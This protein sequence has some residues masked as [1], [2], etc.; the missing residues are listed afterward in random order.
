LPQKQLFKARE[1]AAKLYLD[2]KLND[3]IVDLVQASRSPEDYDSDLQRW[4]R[5][6]ASPRA[7][8]ALARCARARAWLDGDDFVAP[9]HIQSVAPDVLRHR[10]LL[11][12]EG[13]AEGV[14]TDAYIRRLLEV[15]A[16]P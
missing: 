16:I 12:F 2:A 1:D 8:I 14:T 15:A 11:T 3:Y 7:T 6:G 5:F 10:I 9:H 13:E 4:C